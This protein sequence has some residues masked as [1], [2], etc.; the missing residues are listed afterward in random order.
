MISFRF[1]SPEWKRNKTINIGEKL[2]KRYQRLHWIYK[3]EKKS[4]YRKHFSGIELKNRYIEISTIRSY[5]ICKSWWSIL[6][7]KK[8]SAKIKNTS[9]DKIH[10]VING[11]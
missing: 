3:L 4:N 1:D 8:S 2:I 5:I 7:G 11:K 10:N 6:R 9:H